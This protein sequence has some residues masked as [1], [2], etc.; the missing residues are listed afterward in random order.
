MNL[1]SVAPTMESIQDLHFLPSLHPTVIFKV[2]P[3]F[4]TEY[5]KMCYLVQ[6]NRLRLFRIHIFTPNIQNFHRETEI[7]D[8]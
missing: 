5:I 8:K 3:V 2:L 1:R 7:K 6:N 4:T